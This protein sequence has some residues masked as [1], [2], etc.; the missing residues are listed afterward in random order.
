MDIKDF[1]KDE[2]KIELQRRIYRLLTVCTEAGGLVTI[3]SLRELNVEDFLAMLVLNNI[4][5]SFRFMKPE[6]Q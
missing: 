5:S 1:L 4:E 6:N 2:Q 3:E